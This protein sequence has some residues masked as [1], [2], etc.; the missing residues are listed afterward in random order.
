[1]IDEVTLV[2][3]LLLDQYAHKQMISMIVALPCHHVM[4]LQ[5]ALT[6]KKLNTVATEREMHIDTTT[7]VVHTPEEM[8]ITVH[9][10]VE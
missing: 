10:R 3:N 4:T 6:E 9:S 1:M 5:D 8:T 2:T 7:E